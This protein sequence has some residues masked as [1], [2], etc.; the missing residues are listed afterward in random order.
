MSNFS[1]FSI[2][3]L[4]ISE[5]SKR[6]N[7]LVPLHDLYDTIVAKI[8]EM[9]EEKMHLKSLEFFLQSI[10]NMPEITDSIQLFTRKGEYYV[11]YSIKMRKC[12]VEEFNLDED[13]PCDLNDFITNSDYMKYIEYAMKN[14]TNF[15]P[16]RSLNDNM[17]ATHI[18][19]HAGSLDTLKLFHNL[20]TLDLE[21]KTKTN[22][23]AFDIAR[24]KNDIAMLEY[25]Y[26][27]KNDQTTDEL[28]NQI[29]YFKEG[30]N[31][32]EKYLYVTNFVMFSSLLVNIVGIV[33]FSH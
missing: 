13:M 12:L 21:I 1:R 29:Y 28:R 4:I 16:D 10:N 2:E 6:Q 31:L 22:K 25:L 3:I 33:Y 24:E 8:P 26:V 11:T 32:Y 27:I 19:V 5:L 20:Y 7:E 17:N 15:H 23:S 14:D 18:I 9:G 30:I